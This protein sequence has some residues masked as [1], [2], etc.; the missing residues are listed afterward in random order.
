MSGIIERRH[1]RDQLGEAIRDR[2]L[3]QRMPANQSIGENALASELG[4]SRTPV[5]E[6]LLG[7]ERDGISSGPP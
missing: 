4:V 3:H 6:T 5:R 1:L 2:I 7:L